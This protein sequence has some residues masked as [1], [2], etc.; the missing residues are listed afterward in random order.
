MLPWESVLRVWDVLLFQG[1]R[2]HALLKQLLPFEWELYWDHALLHQK[3]ARDAV[4]LLQSLAGLTFDSIQL[5]LPLAWDLA[6]K[7]YGFKENKSTN[8][9]LSRM[10]SESSTAAA[11]LKF[12]NKRILNTAV[13]ISLMFN[14]A[15]DFTIAI[16]VLF[17]EEVV[18]QVYILG[19]G[20]IF[21]LT[22][23]AKWECSSYGRALALHARGTG[24]SNHL[25]K[26]LVAFHE[27][28]C[29]KDIVLRKDD[30]IFG[31]TK[32]SL[33]DEF[34]QIMHNRFQMSSMGA[35]TFFLGTSQT[36][37]GWDLH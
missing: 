18:L 29:P 16:G 12:G 15:I 30:I 7:L 11:A 4:T 22:A 36:E 26:R 1:N 9:G 24:K 35:L 28:K 32:K 31:S 21:T 25:I 19:P 14:A 17:K 37:K 13:V 20:C 27:K 6:S 23:I 3:D 34:E 5:V 2:V 33:C 10:D 8:G